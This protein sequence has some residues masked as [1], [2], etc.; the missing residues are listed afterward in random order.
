M[1][2]Y[3]NRYQAKKAAGYG[4]IVVRVEGGYTVMSAENYKIWKRQK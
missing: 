1:T 2:I 4:D 3:K